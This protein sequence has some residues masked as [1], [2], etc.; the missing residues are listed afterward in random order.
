VSK[1]KLIIIGPLPPPYHGVTISTSLVLA[2][3]RLHEC[4][5]VAHLDTSD[6]RSHENIGTWDVQNVVLGLRNAV[7][8]ALSLRGSTG[9]VYLPISQGIAFL[10]DSLF[11]HLA[12][13]R[14]WKV[15][16]HLRGSEFRDFYRAAN[17]LMRRWIRATM[18]QPSSVGVMGESLRAVFGDLVRADRIA[19][20][21]NG[22]PD[23]EPNSIVRDGST[24]LFLSHLRRRKGIVE[25]VEA[26]LHVLAQ[27]PDVQ[28]LFV[29]QWEN[30]DLERELL[31]K[32][33]QA[34]D[35]IRFLP[36]ALGEKKRR[37]LLSSSV[38]LFPPVEPEGHPRVVLEAIAAGLPVVTTARGAIVDTVVDGE[39]G[40]V[41]DGP[42]EPSELAHR[43]LRLLDDE[44]LRRRMSEAAR[45]RY[46]E[47]FTQDQ[48]DR[49]LAEWLKDVAAVIQP[50]SSRAIT[51]YES[52]W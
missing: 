41:L 51:S 36:M 35:G 50:R 24:V 30:S 12:R 44:E 20:V 17:P 49:L 22:T 46:L 33:A 34:G 2:N 5:D 48:A 21:P 16:V 26:A 39:N 15:V 43:L 28:F 11:I 27:K 37:L 3:A 23:P 6:H 9:V 47:R 14:G 1:P 42:A 13:A 8:L 45:T 52:R 19:V 40:F 25:S 7:R 18:R 38:F 31:N 29:G 32:T 4:F 10:R